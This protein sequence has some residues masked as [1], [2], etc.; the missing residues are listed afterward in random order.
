MMDLFV[1]FDY[2]LNVIYV[3]WA[4]NLIVQAIIKFCS[5]LF[6]SGLQVSDLVGNPGNRFSH[7]AA[8]MYFRV[9]RAVTIFAS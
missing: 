1:L 3:L 5:V 6:C 9:Y 4:K 2:I 7:D 8:Q